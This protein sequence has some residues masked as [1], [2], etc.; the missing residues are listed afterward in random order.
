M[1]KVNIKYGG[2]NLQLV[3]SKKLV[4]IRPI[5]Y[6]NQASTF[7]DK[8]IT[9]YLTGVKL[10]QFNILNLS[11]SEE[12]IETK[13]DNLRLSKNVKVGT[14]VYYTSDDEVP[15]VPSGEIYLKFRSMTSKSKA[16]ELIDKHHLQITKVIGENELVVRISKNSLNPIKVVADLQQS[17]Q[18]IIAEPD[19]NT[20]GQL[21]TNF[22]PPSDTLLD[23]QWHLK[24]VGNHR[25]TSIGLKKGADARVVKAWN[26]AQSL[27]DPSIIVAVIDDGFDLNHPDFNSPGKI[28]A[29][30]DFT[31]NNSDP[32][33]NYNEGYPYYDRNYN[34]WIGDWHGTACAG[35]AVGSSNEVGIL[36]AAPNCRLMPIRWGTDLSDK[37]IEKWF[38]YVLVQGA[39]VVSCS[40]GAAAKVFILSERQKK[41][42][43]RCATK[44]RNNKGIVICFAAGNSNRDIDAPDGSSHDG[45]ANHPNVIAVSAINSRD[46]KSSY[47]NFGKNI[48]VC[49]PSSGSGGMGITTSDV[50]GYFTRNGQ[51]ISS[52]YNNGDF[53]DDFGGTSSACPLVAGICAL[54]VSLNPNLTAKEMKDIIEQTARKIGPKSSYDK[55]GHS[56]FFGYGCINAEKASE[57]VINQMK[58][59][60]KIEFESQA[61]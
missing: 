61:L 36:G 34:E 41:A 29:P 48:S 49:A 21:W 13:L 58:Y 14:H 12:S 42:I 47:S 1:D 18:V 6:R 28:I 39:S 16:H 33:P 53:T 23:N 20:P 37:S 51:Q 43:E 59:K 11:K 24:N 4:G 45:F 32:S 31:R 56:K 25:G 55:N 2:Q 30:W 10:A 22:I 52:G 57:R 46:Y 3:K 5:P 26:K 8:N 9:D 7:I 19:L 44:G 40:W 60:A 17:D 27:G 15:F 54:L 38:N 35:I 50:T